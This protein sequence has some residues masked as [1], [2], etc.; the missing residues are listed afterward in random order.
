VKETSE[1][2]ETTPIFFAIKRSI[3]Q[4]QVSPAG[5]GPFVNFTDPSDH[6]DTK[7]SKKSSSSKE[8]KNEWSR[9]AKE[10]LRTVVENHPSRSGAGVAA[11]LG[12]DGTPEKPGDP[13]KG[14]KSQVTSDE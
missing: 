11:N 5:M 12:P 10:T 2:A 1:K 4:L 6:N 13:N 8:D 7:G 9:D 14:V 3:E